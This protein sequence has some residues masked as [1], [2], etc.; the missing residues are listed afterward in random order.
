MRTT[1]GLLARKLRASI[2]FVVLK[3]SFWLDHLSAFHVVCSH[4]IKIAF[5]V[6]KEFHFQLKGRNCKIKQNGNF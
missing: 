5:S 1:N 4:A 2:S 6:H 3:H